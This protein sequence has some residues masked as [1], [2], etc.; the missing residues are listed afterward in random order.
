MSNTVKTVLKVIGSAIFGVLI[1]AIALVAW[2]TVTEFKPEEREIIAN[3]KNEEA[4]LS[5]G[6]NLTVLTFNT[7]YAGLG[8]KSDF[9]MDGGENVR[10]GDK[11]YV[12]KNIE[13]I[14]NIILNTSADITLLQEVDEASKRSFFVNQCSKYSS[15]ADWNSSFVLNYSCDYVPFPLPTIGMVESGIM[16][17]SKPSPVY[18]ERI[19]LPCPFS[20]PVRAANIKRCLLMTKYNLEESEKQLVVINFH[21]E[22]YDDGEGKI[23]QTKLLWSI[24]E[25][26]YAKGNYVIAGGDFNQ[27]FPGVL[28]SYPIKNPELWT[29]GILEEAAGNWQYA[30]DASNPTCRLL[31]EPYDENSENTQYYVIDGFIVSGNIE[32]VKVETVNQNFEFSDHNPVLLEVKLK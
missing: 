8:E 5:T 27:S 32:I 29:P 12:L 25:E 9:F 11:D 28:E 21:L 16:T 4:N 20:W 19:S 15:L 26:E 1:L 10:T 3:G 14:S 23:A 24:L 31:N 30:Y 22:A 7:G 17:L 18:I 2:L 13:G 6:N